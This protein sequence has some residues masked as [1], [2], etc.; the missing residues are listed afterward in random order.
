MISSLEM[1]NFRCFENVKTSLKRF[2]FIVGRSGTGKTALLEAL[3]LAGGG[4]PEIYFRLRRWRGFGEN[5]ELSG[6][7]ASYES[8]FRDLF[9]NFNQHAGIYIRT[10][11]PDRGYRKLEISY[12]GSATLDLPL[13]ATSTE[14]EDSFTVTPITFKWDTPKGVKS[15]RVEVAE[16]RFRMSG[17]QEVSP[18]VFV[19]PQTQNPRQNAIKYSDLS[20]QNEAGRVL[21]ALQGVFPNVEG[22]SLEFSAGEPMLYVSVAGIP[23]KLPLVVLSGGMN[24]YLSIILAILTVPGG[25]VIVD[26]MENGFYYENLPLILK[27]LVTLCRETKT[28]LIATTHSYEF[29]EALAEVMDDKLEEQSALLRLEQEQP[30]QAPNIRFIPGNSYR[31]A[32]ASSF[33]VR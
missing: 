12:E 28:Q 3:F 5:V 10:D 6:T 19:S 26:E 32:I 25:A 13:R 17:T 20:R 24:K 33:E 30:M 31:S 11:D 15:S 14:S 7:R 4:N 8:V 16:N 23:E 22:M 1:R 21:E 9:Y 2:T 18:M 29:L 27:T